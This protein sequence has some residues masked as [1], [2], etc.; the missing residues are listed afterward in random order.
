MCSA[1]WQPV[2]D[3]N[4][5]FCGRDCLAAFNAKLVSEHDA[6]LAGLDEDG[7]QPDAPELLPLRPREGDAVV[8][9]SSFLALRG[10]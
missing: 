4:D 9:V 7:S 2:E 8:E 1:V 6:V 5:S 3:G 10:C